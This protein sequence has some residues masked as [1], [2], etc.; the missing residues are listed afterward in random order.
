MDHNAKETQPKVARSVT[1]PA[2]A[3]I[4]TEQ[5]TLTCKFT[6]DACGLTNIEFQ[7]PVRPVALDVVT[8][9][10]TVMTRAVMKSHSAL[11]PDCHP[12]TISKIYI[13][14]EDGERKAKHIG[15]IPKMSEP[16]SI[17]EY[18]KRAKANLRYEGRFADTKTI[19][20]CPFCAAPDWLV[21]PVTA[22]MDDY[23]QIQDPRTCKECGRTAALIITRTDSGV[24]QELVQ[25]AGPDAPEWLTPKPRRVAPENY[26]P[27]KGTPLG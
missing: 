27:G 8:W 18:N 22:A 5:R 7:V 9:M 6:C 1:N 2:R 12:K 14:I 4:M 23:K 15:A 10:K 26:G 20:P 11:S 3:K 16:T 13:P 21:Y 19:L 24:Q 17:E 25:I